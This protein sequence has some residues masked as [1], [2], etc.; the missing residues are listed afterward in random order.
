MNYEYPQSNCELEKM[1]LCTV[2]S[3]CMCEAVESIQTNI[4]EDL[5]GLS[6]E[7][8]RKYFNKLDEKIKEIKK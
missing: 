2:D 5:V 3:W 6:K 7:W 1:G 4:E 8:K